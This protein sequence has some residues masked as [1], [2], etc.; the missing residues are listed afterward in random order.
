MPTRRLE[1]VTSAPAVPLLA[2]QQ[3][4]AGP[5]RLSSW[6]QPIVALTTGRV[7]GYEAL[8]RFGNYRGPVADRFARAWATGSGPTL[9][10]DALREALA[11]TD[12]PASTYLAVNV[13]PR[14]ITDRVVRDILDTDLTGIVVELTEAH[15]LPTPELRGMAEWLRERN[16]RLAIDDVGTGYAGLERLITVRPDLIKLDRS[17]VAHLLDDVV[18]RL[19]VESLVSFARRIDASVVAEGIEDERL[20]EVVAEL[21]VSYGQGFLFGRA[22]PDW[23]VPGAEAVR[24]ATQVHQQALSAT[25]KQAAFLDELVLLERISDRFGEADELVDVHHAVAA[26]TRLVGADDVAI[27]LVSADQEN[28]LTLSHHTWVNTGASQLLADNPLYQWVVDTRRAAQVLVGDPNADAGQQERLAD[29]GFGGLLVLPVI[30]RG[31]T[32]GL[33]SLFRL[34]P[35]PWTLAEMRLVRIGTSS[36]AA[37]LDRLVLA[38]D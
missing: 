31:E 5:E 33:L 14:A 25:P 16:A 28:L 6:V 24:A 20:L 4:S 34:E 8:A 13:S 32:I 12:R 19:M 9:E 2:P 11:L 35:E 29:L 22:A 26:L 17:L 38:T 37:T 18:S 7:A 15:D 27:D 10:A 3:D 23:T 21:D 36:L 1:T 30:T